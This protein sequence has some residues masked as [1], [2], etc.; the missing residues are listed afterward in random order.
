M[1]SAVGFW[2]DPE[3]GFDFENPSLVNPV[4]DD[5][6]LVAPPRPVNILEPFLFLRG[7]GPQQ[8]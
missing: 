3:R 1:C 5:V 6:R 7:V 8:S 4:E 2:I